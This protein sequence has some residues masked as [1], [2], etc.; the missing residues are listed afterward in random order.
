[1]VAKIVSG[2]Q[3]GADRAALD[4]AL[5]LGIPVGGWCP[6]G[7]L[8]ED[9]RVPARY[10]LRETTSDKYPQRTEW[11][12]RDADATLVCT[13]GRPGRGTALTIRLAEKLRKP[14]RV[15][16][17]AAGDPAAVAAWLATHRVRVLN[18]AGPRES[19]SPGVHAEVAA[20]LRAVLASNA[21]AA[22]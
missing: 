4:V 9:G 10:T 22:A 19:N 16:D 20:F 15:V 17:P 11:N 5:E 7:R 13:R 12:V 21:A 6:R 14:C 3:T 1:M 2:G 8:A 18:V